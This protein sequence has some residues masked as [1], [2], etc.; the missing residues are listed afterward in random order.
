VIFRQNKKDNDSVRCAVIG[1]GYLG[2][3]HAEKLSRMSNAELVAVVDIQPAAAAELAGR[4]KA[5][6]ITD[7]RKLPELGVQCATI[8]TTT[9]THFE[10]ANWLLQNGIDVLVEKPMAANVQQA[11]NML[12][13]AREYGRILQVGH[14]E[15][16][17]P[18]F[19]AMEE[20]I[21]NPRFFEVRRIAEF[22]GRGIDVDV[23]LDL[24]IHDIDIVAHLVGRPIVRVEALGMPI[25][26]ESVDIANARLT[27]EGGAVA[28]V[29]ASR[30]AF[31]SERTIRVF[32]SDAYLSMDYGKK[33]LKIYTKT[34]RKTMLGYPEVN[35]REV[36]VKEL[37]ALERELQSFVN[38]VQTRSQPLVTGE[39][40]LRAMELA[41]LI[42]RAFRDSW[43]PFTEVIDTTGTSTKL[44]VNA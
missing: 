23:V 12:E 11:R 2:K 14:L 44:V 42:A 28:N 31:K 8:V 37:D 20:A 4:F 26:T 35:V 34:G 21:N 33:K 16:F 19:T 18:A 22:T 24:M 29:T 1:A 43:V 15:R 30:A 13:V 36:P 41:A 38:C 9:S 6:A 5:L 7:Y 27:F 40:G 25:L 32:Q 39:D 3:Y 17:N 10:I